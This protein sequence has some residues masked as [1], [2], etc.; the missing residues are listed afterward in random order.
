MRVRNIVGD[1]N[2]SE[3]ETLRR[4]FNNLLRMIE[5]AETSLGAG[6]TAEAVLQ[7]FADA[8]R[9]GVDANNDS[10]TNVTGTQATIVGLRPTPTPRKTAQFNAATQDDDGFDL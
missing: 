6:A 3:F 9:D 2:S 4:G 7:A 5:G 10:E 1:Q 8:V